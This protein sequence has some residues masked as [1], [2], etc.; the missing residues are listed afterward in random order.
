MLPDFHSVRAPNIVKLCLRTLQIAKVRQGT[1]YRRLATNGGE[2]CG[3]VCLTGLRSIDRIGR[4]GRGHAAAEFAKIRYSKLSTQALIDMRCDI[5]YK[6]AKIISARGNDTI[7]F[8]CK[9]CLR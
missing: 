2:K 5:R 4:S 9:I 3:L 6:K 8:Q 1:P 7:N